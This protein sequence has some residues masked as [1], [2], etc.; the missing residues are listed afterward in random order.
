M[1][2]NIINIDAEREAGSLNHHCTPA[3]I[4]RS[5]EERVLSIVRQSKQQQFSVKFWEGEV[6]ELGYIGISKAFKKIVKWAK[7]NKQPNVIIGEDDL[8]FSAPG[9]WQ[10]YIENLPEDYDIY[11]GGIYYGDIEKGRIVKG[12]SGHTLIMVH[13]RFYDFF[14]A[15]DPNHHLDTWLGQYCS[16]KKYIV[17]E[18]FVVTQISEGYS[19]NHK[20]MVSHSAYLET[21]VLFGIGS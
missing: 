21:M 13:E 20:R 14:L 4:K 11:F 16:E 7:E 18:P 15:A 19:D 6:A 8:V 5:R 1:V 10:Y 12:Y 3:L 17:C 9:A 2:I